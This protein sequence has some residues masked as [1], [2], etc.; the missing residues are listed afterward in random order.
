VHNLSDKVCV[1]LAGFHSGAKTVL[2]KIMFRMSLCELR[3]NR[4]IKPKVLGTII[5]NL[6]YLHHFGSYFTEHLVPGLDPVTHKP[7]I[8]AMDAIGNI[9][10]PRDFV[11]I[12]TGAEYLFG[13]YQS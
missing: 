2:D 5:S 1:G 13:G 4:C 9:S 6:T 11:A 8:C 10:T 7:Y 3:E 12:G